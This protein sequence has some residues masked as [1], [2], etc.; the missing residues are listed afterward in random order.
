MVNN[1]S[2]DQTAPTSHK[3]T[4]SCI[5]PTRPWPLSSENERLQK[6]NLNTSKSRKHTDRHIDTQKKKRINLETRQNDQKIS[7]EQHN[8][9]QKRKTQNLS[10]SFLLQPSEHTESQALSAFSRNTTRKHIQTQKKLLQSLLHTLH[11]WPKE[12]SIS[13]HTRAE[14][15]LLQ[16]E[17]NQHGAPEE[18]PPSPPKQA[19]LLRCSNKR[20]TTS[21]KQQHKLV[22]RRRQ[23]K[24]GFFL[25]LS[26]SLSPSLVSLSL[27]PSLPLSRRLSSAVHV[28]ARVRGFGKRLPCLDHPA[29]FPDLWPSLSKSSSE[30]ISEPHIGL[31][32]SSP[33]EFQT[34]LLTH[35]PNLVPKP[36]PNL[37]PELW[38]SLLPR[39]RFPL[40]VFR[41]LSS[42]EG[43]YLFSVRCQCMYLLPTHLDVLPPHF[44]FLFLFFFRGAGGPFFFFC[45]LDFSSLFFPFLFL[46]RKQE[47]F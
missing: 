45:V 2:S 17:A 11:T 27:P 1:Q 8:S 13:F 12:E 15:E 34:Y 40:G 20:Y 28:S 24:R 29:Y 6:E 37:I 31:R 26:L 4:P 30:P 44:F 39:V 38:L 19:D 33:A 21:G 35:P 7:R 10:L 5:P 42:E 3:K 16:Q 46:W 23:N 41:C 14:A 25:S 43:T 22:Q 18:P 9:K 36:V 47:T 32:T